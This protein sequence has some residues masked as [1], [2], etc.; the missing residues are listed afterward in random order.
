MPCGAQ[1]DLR[2]LARSNAIPD[3]SP[4]LRLFK[5]MCAA[6]AALLAS[7]A[8]TKGHTRTLPPTPSMPD[9]V[10]DPRAFLAQM[11]DPPR[12]RPRPAR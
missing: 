11:P 4:V 7:D 6:A 2:E 10:Y 9:A 12:P 1:D 5:R 8:H 3:N